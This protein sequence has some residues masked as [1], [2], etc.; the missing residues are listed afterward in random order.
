MKLKVA[1]S[2]SSFAQ[3]SDGP[4]KMLEE[5]GFQVALNPYGRRLTED[6]IIAHLKGVAG[7]IAGTEPLT[8]KV[9]SS[10]HALKAIARV[11]IGMENVDLTVAE[12]LGIKVSNTPDCPPQ[13]VSEMAIAALLTLCRKLISMNTSLHSGHWKRQIGVSLAGTKVLVVG[14]GR[15]GREMARLLR[16]FGARVFVCDPLID[17][18]SVVEGEE[19]VRLDDGLKIADVITL[20]ASGKDLILGKK[21]FDNMRE[22]VIVLNSARGELMDESAL[23]EALQNGKVAGAWCDAFSQEPYKG[24]LIEFEQVLLTPHASAYTRQCRLAMEIQAVQNLIR[25]LKEAT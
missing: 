11:G 1:I 6:E 24:R 3:I 15:I 19:V 10:A 7:L 23:I 21:E 5:A 12:E 9:L 13:S 17:K 8:Q 22:G 25:D 4:K 14:Y 20:H 2:T 18:S 16:G